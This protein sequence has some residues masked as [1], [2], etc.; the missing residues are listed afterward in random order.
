MTKK[1]EAIDRVFEEQESERLK[2]FQRGM[3]GMCDQLLIK[4]NHKVFQDFMSGNDFSAII[5]RNVS[6]LIQ[7]E[8]EECEKILDTL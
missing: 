1:Q 3:I 8:K 7:K 2:E 5:L 6:R 4:I